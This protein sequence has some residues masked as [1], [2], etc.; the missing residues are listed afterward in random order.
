MELQLRSS[1]SST[2][3]TRFQ[4]STDN[5]TQQHSDSQR[6][7]NTKTSTSGDSIANSRPARTNA[8]RCF[9][10]GERGHI[11]TACP[12]QSKRGLIIQE[13]EDLEPQYDDYDATDDENNEIIKGDTCLN[14]VLGR[15]CLLPR[16][17]QESWLR[18]N[19]FRSTCTINGRICKLIIDSGSCT[20]VM[21]YEATQK[22][23][24]TVTPHPSPYPLAWLNNGTELN[25]SKQVLVSFSIGNYKDSVTCDVIPMDACHLLLGRPWQF[26]RDATHRGKANTYSFVFDASLSIF[27]SELLNSSSS[28]CYI[29]ICFSPKILKRPHITIIC[30]IPYLYISH[31]KSIS[32]SWYDFFSFKTLISL[33]NNNDSHCFMHIPCI[34]S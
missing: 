7:D 26:D 21:S 28:L 4:P 9:S 31:L 5:N 18:T 10:C 1:W 29:L 17:S 6:T 13:Q 8:L 3:R 19:L 27:S 15:N 22:L 34:L 33:R 30:I 2:S 20:N 32:R 25:V 14:L 23:G 16:A 24:L 12:K 11:Q